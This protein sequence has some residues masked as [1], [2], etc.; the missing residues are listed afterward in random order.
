MT[1]NNTTPATTAGTDIAAQKATVEAVFTALIKGITNDLPTVDPFNL[2]GK[3]IP[4]ATVLSSLQARIDAA[5]K[6]KAA[7]TA[8]HWPSRASRPSFSTRTRCARS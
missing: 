4:R 7:R 5:E 1:T 2:G 3:A 6:T 8:F